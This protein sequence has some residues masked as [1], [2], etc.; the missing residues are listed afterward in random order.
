MRRVGCRVDGGDCQH[1][2][3]QRLTRVS[4]PHRAELVQYLQEQPWGDK[5]RRYFLT[6]NEEYVGGLEA[7]TNVW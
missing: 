7:I 6:R 5:S 1:V 3:A 2:R 4:V